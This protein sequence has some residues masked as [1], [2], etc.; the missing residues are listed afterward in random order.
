MA[1]E[2]RY[3]II[4]S[5]IKIFIFVTFLLIFYCSFAYADAELIFER[6][7]KAVVVVIAY[8]ELGKPISQGSGFIVRSDGRVVTNYHLISNANNI[9]VMSGSKTLN[10]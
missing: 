3:G 7:S 6:N 9:K 4:K 2:M 10:L 1:K 5:Y 8:D